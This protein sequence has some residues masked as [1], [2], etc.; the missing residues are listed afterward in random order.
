MRRGA[1]LL[2][3]VLALA[4]AC[5]PAR[6]QDPLADA[7]AFAQGADP[8]GGKLLFLAGYNFRVE[9]AQFM[10]G[11]RWLQ[12]QGGSCASCHGPTG[13]GGM[14]PLQCDLAAPAVDFATLAGARPGRE[15]APYDVD[16]LRRA[17]EQSVDPDGGALDQC[18]PKW[19]LGT[20]DF[21][22]LTA[23]LLSLG[24]P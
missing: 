13:L 20:K 16:S 14:F 18:M 19:Y 22:D 11:P 2:A 5:G 21:R 24:R 10:G 9:R 7:R 8:L 15:G 6:A 4:L 17:L 3:A 1:L 23:H 12:M